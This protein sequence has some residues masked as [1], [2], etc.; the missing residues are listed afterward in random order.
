[1]AKIQASDI[2]NYFFPIRCLICEHIIDRKNSICFECST[3][4]KFSH[5]EKKLHENELTELFH[6]RIKFHQAY[7]FLKA[8]SDGVAK[9][10]VHQIKYRSN[11]QLM[12]YLANSIKSKIADQMEYDYLLPVPLNVKKE[13]Q[14]GYNQS[15]LIAN[16]IFGPDKILNDLIIRKTNTKTQTGFG[17]FERWKNMEEAFEINQKKIEEIEN[18]ARILI[19]DDVVT[20]GATIESILATLKNKNANFQ[21]SILTLMKA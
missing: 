18:D 6:G 20:T 12:D 16:S 8:D 4:L 14:R 17:K 10:I 3:K 21:F 7:Y 15:E 19:I 13:K 11:F 1:M 9:S 5:S 2:L